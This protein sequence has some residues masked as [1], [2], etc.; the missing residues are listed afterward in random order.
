MVFEIRSRD[1]PFVKEFIKL[2]TNKKHRKNSSRVAVEGPNLISEALNSGYIPDLIFL[3][4]AY[5]EKDYA[6]IKTML[7]QGI[8]TLI[9]NEKLFKQMADTDTPQEVA[10]IFNFPYLVADKVLAD[11]GGLVLILDR[12]SD[13]GNVGT[14]IRTAAAAG[15]S[16]VTYTD[17]CADP[18]GPKA[19]RATAG[20][21]FRLNPELLPKPLEFLNL[22]N[23]K[24]FQ[25]VAATSGK[26]LDYRLVDFTKPTALIIGKESEGVSAELCFVADLEVTIPLH[27]GVDSLN[28]AVAAGILLFEV[29]RSR[30]N[31]CT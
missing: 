3:T 24:G 8:K 31:H 10:A 27:G 5:L 4:R 29:I 2:K 18:Y 11:H 12:I 22:L 14:I 25:V 13:P 15:A 28:A 26:G 30:N 16:Q 19:L 7:P 20:A 1:N 23:K 21:I 17:D 6:K 9:V